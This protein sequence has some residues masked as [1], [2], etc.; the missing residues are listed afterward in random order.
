MK[1]PAR[2]RCRQ[3]EA[4]F[5]LFPLGPVAVLTAST[6]HPIP[7]QQ[8]A[9]C[10]LIPGHGR[11]AG[12]SHTAA[13]VRRECGLGDVECIQTIHV[14]LQVW[15]LGEVPAACRDKSLRSQEGRTL[16]PRQ[17]G[18]LAAHQAW[19]PQAGHPATLSSMSR[20]FCGHFSET[21]HCNRE[22]SFGVEQ[23][24]P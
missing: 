7:G 8:H 18:A 19:Q 15:P 1:P 20:C 6:L 23:C 9:P 22:M 14:W 17:W 4:L 5:P 21:P 10:L 24:P 12:C 2:Q 3:C 13:P 11:Q 16:V